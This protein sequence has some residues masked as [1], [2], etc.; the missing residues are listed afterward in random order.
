VKTEFSPAAVADLEAI[1][2]YI[3]RDNPKAAATWVDR[4]VDRAEKAAVAPRVGRVV[5]EVGNPEIREVFVR[6]YRIIYRIEADRI[7]VLTVF[8]G[9]RRL[10]RLPTG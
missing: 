10:K 9:H 6:T 7:L 2:R 5:P 8:E 4:L 1:A 3:T